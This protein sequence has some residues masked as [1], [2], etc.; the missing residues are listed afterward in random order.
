ML[1]KGSVLCIDDDENLQIILQDF[2]QAEG[3]D[4]VKA[5]TAAE[6][7]EKIS[8]AAPDAILLDL[9][10][11]DGEG[12]GLV[13]RLKK[14]TDAAIIVVSGKNETT[15]K[16]VCLEIGADDYITKPFE[17]IELSARLKAVIRRGKESP[18]EEK[19]NGNFAPQENEIIRFG[20]GWQLDRAQ[21][22]LFDKNKNSADLTTGQFQL[23]EALVNSPNRALSRDYLFELTRGSEL[24]AFDRAIDIQISRL[25]QKLNDNQKP[26]KLIKTVRG[27]GYMFC[28]DVEAQK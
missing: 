7:M 15:E 23:L 1:H 10:L 12:T 18:D 11:P 3:Y 2:L 24:E 16:V 22:Q 8:S 14:Q 27:I 17:I 21:F 6:A 13:A 19:V 9:M 5:S 26:P 28:G 4:F 25:R 20:D